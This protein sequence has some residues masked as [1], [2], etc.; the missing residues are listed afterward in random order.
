MQNHTQLSLS[1]I[2]GF[3]TWYPNRRAATKIMQE[4]KQNKQE[5]EQNRSFLDPDKEAQRL[6]DLLR[7]KHE[8]DMM[9][10]AQKHERDRI[11]KAQKHERD[12]ID[13]K[14]KLAELHMKL[15]DKGILS[16]SCL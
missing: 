14:L 1:R 8:R 10:K 12:M 16:F 7:W 9:D 6:H 5:L 3:R 2:L 4:G 13:K 15:A 11:D